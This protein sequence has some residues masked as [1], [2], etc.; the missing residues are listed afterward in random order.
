MQLVNEAKTSATTAERRM[1]LDCAGLVLSKPRVRVCDYIILRG[2]CALLPAG[3]DC[4]LI[5][6][7]RLPPLSDPIKADFW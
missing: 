4:N 1:A 2:Q 5:A 7:R 3:N 6:V